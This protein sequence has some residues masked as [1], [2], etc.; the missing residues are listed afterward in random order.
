MR[1]I[2]VQL[3]LFLAIISG[4]SQE[5]SGPKVI[6]TGGYNY[7][8]DFTVDGSHVIHCV[9]SHQLGENY[10]K[11]Y[12][13]RSADKGNTWSAPRDI[14]LNTIRWMAN[15]HIVSDN[16][17]HLHVTYDFNTGD[18][19]ATKIA[20]IH[21][22]GS[23]WSAPVFISDSLP[24]PA[25]HNRLA[26]DSNNKIFC[27]WYRG[28]IVY[29]TQENGIWS[30]YCQPYPY[31]HDMHF[32]HRLVI[33]EQNE[34]HC[35]GLH[36]GKG[37]Y[38]ADNRVVAF[39]MNNGVWS[40][41]VELSDTLGGE[42]SDVCLVVDTLPAY[43]WGQLRKDT[44]SYQEAIY[45]AETTPSQL[46][47]PQMISWDAT[48]VAMTTDFNGDVQIV[49]TERKNDS[50]YQLVAYSS[51]Q[52]PL[53]KTVI[54]TGSLV[55]DRNLL[56]S[57]DTSLYLVT[58]RMEKYN[59]NTRSV[60]FFKKDILPAGSEETPSIH[61]SI[62]PNPFSA[63]LSVRLN[64]NRA[65]E[66]TISLLDYLGRPAGMIFNG[67][68]SIGTVTYSADIREWNL[69]PGIYLV[70]IRHGGKVS[71]LKAIFL[72]EGFENRE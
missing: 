6:S 47:P 14:S 55:Y 68:S 33:G 28:N 57:V 71:C 50:L 58:L 16:L 64:V 10:F 72:P 22:N 46:T 36:H 23:T 3:F 40:G 38:N 17:N 1:L 20:Y 15:P 29:R 44:S 69:R 30:G 53:K 70:Q 27:F 26:I 39:S 66:M 37:Q 35:I 21:Y 12:Y 54:V 41:L 60:V 43:A 7:K 25:M 13:S 34:L 31:D 32:L 51:G 18:Y 24:G 65:R 42:S 9:W 4:Q 48:D 59:D 49:N 5:W 56:K 62:F 52:F 2:I 67:T 8:P 61:F 45:F 11:I 63:K 19:T